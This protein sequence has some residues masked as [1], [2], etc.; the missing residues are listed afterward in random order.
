MLGTPE[1]LNKGRLH[2]RCLDDINTLSQYAG[3][4]AMLLADGIKILNYKSQVSSMSICG[5]LVETLI[6]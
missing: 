1:K 3:I 6:Y 5:I 4:Q 2:R